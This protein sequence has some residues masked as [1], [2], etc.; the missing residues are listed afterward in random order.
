MLVL[1]RGE[2]GFLTSLR[3]GYV[4]AVAEVA[5]E[6]VHAVLVAAGHM[7]P[8]IEDAL[9]QLDLKPPGGERPGSTVRV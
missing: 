8:L 3:V 6:P 7:T 1:T 4:L 2:P 9:A 5:D